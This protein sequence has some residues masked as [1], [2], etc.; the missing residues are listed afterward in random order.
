MR[1]HLEYCVHFW[2]F[3][4]K[5]D[6]EML[7]SVQRRAVKLRRQEHKSYGEWLSKLGL[8]I[9]SSTRIGG[10]WSCLWQGK[11]DDPWDP[12]QPK[13]FCDSMFVCLEK[14]KFRGDLIA[15]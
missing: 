11:F 1:P 7:E 10:W 3:H 5:K 12:F 6:F 14:K 4:Y 8:F 9:W 15:L 13:T 2:A